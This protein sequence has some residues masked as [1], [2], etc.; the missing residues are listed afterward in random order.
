MKNIVIT[1]VSTGIGYVITKALLKRGY[2]VFGSVRKT[3]DAQRLA[4]ELGEHFQPLLF[5]VTDEKAIQLAADQVAQRIGSEGVFAL[6]NNAGIAV[7][8]PILHLPIDDWR[9]QFEINVFGL[10]AVTKAFAPL[11]GARKD[12]PH[13]PGKI[14]NVGS[15][16]GTFAHPFM[17]PYS[18]SKH[19]LEGLSK[20]LR[21]EMLLYGIDVVVL[22]PGVVK[23]PIW[24]KA[25]KEDPN[26]YDHTDYGPA[27]QKLQKMMLEHSEDGF[28]QE[29]FGKIV[30]DII[31]TK[32]PKF[33]YVLVANKLKNWTAM[34]LLPA[35]TLLKI[36]AQ[37]MGLI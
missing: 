36:V 25:K 20:S 24:D 1:G 12:C 13:P 14:F 21:G 4:Q 19:A 2:R 10:I 7:G 26:Q 5:D 6:V 22:A 34:R 15:I 27:L 3:E 29:K 31:E 8:G 9:R 30:A 35:R 33:H 23:T 37:R 16:A 28:E 11:V 17:G 32:E 18:A